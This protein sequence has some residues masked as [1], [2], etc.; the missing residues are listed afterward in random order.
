MS[1]WLY[2]GLD[3]TC[4]FANHGFSH[5]RGSCLGPRLRMELSKLDHFDFST[6]PEAGLRRQMAYGLDMP[7]EIMVLPTNHGRV[8]PGRY[9]VLQRSVSSQEWNVLF[10]EAIEV[11]SVSH[12]S[13]YQYAI[14]GVGINNVLVVVADVMWAVLPRTNIFPAR[15]HATLSRI[16]IFGC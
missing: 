16:A 6:R 2:Y 15:L 8:E 10:P 14:A 5:G 9:F 3:P 11:L 1:R 13:T 4:A 7:L 12:P